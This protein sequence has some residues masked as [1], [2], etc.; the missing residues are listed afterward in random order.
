MRAEDDFAIGEVPVAR[1]VAGHAGEVFLVVL[2]EAVL[3]GAVVLNE[4]KQVRREGRA[5]SDSGQ[6]RALRLLF[7]SDTRQLQRAQLVGFCLGEAPQDVSE[8]RS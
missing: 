1:D 8:L 3:P 5:R 4:A 7:Q 6:I 2:L